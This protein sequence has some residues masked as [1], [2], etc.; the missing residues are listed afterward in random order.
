[1]YKYIGKKSHGLT[2]SY[3]ALRTDVKRYKILKSEYWNINM[4]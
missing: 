2:K 3:E 4:P 1:M